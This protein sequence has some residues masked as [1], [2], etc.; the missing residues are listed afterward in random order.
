M[1][2]KLNCQNYYYTNLCKQTKFLGIPVFFGGYYKW[3][4]AVLELSMK[5]GIIRVKCVQ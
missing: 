3:H 5:A 4:F 2:S 1:Y